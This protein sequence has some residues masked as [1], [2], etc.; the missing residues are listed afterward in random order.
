M[1]DKV[2]L[3]ATIVVE[4]DVDPDFLY[5]DEGNIPARDMESLRR[6]LTYGWANEYDRN[7]D[8]ISIT[9]EPVEGTP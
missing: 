1:T 4:Y 6:R 8:R 3:R 5:G 7:L 9:V 2:R